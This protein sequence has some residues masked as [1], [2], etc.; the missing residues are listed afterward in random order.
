MS[1]FAK[2]MVAETKTWSS[3]Y[4]Q[5]ITGSGREGFTCYAFVEDNDDILFYQHVL[6]NIPNVSYIGCGGKTGVVT[7]FRKLHAESIDSNNL[8]FVDK[9]TEDTPFE[10]NDEILRT[11]FYSWESHVCQPSFVKWV[12]Q[13]K[14]T[15]S[16]TPTQTKTVEKNWLS[17]VKS[18][19][20]ILSWHTALLSTAA[21][22]DASLGI[23]DVSV[24][25]YVENQS[26]CVTP[27]EAA[28]NWLNS[29]LDFALSLG[30]T[31]REIETLRD[32]YLHGFPLYE[33]QGKVLFTI[34]KKF[35]AETARSLN[36]E[37]IGEYS[38]PKHL[39]S[40]MRWDAPATD[41]IREYAE[42]RLA[43]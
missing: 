14:M 32:R 36:R 5:Y 7:L 38:S 28:L 34:L 25:R 10:F 39:A 41:Y 4:L 31:L 24:V 26:G 6:T 29:K 16:L 33:A 17:T 22:L 35:I 8:F 20:D 27:S 23:S 19:A 15:P 3:A 18:F 30:V 21:R 37:Y 2:G 9:D 13:R 42:A 11:R 1:S 43:A 12:L 40:A